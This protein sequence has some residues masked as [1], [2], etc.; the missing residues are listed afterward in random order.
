MT[1]SLLC[2]FQ[3]VHPRQAQMEYTGTR[4][5]AWVGLAPLCA[6]LFCSTL[7]H[8]EGVVASTGLAWS[9]QHCIT[10]AGGKFMKTLWD[11]GFCPHCLCILRFSLLILIFSLIPS[12]PSTICNVH[13]DSTQTHP[14][15]PYTVTVPKHPLHTH[16]FASHR[17]CS[18]V[19]TFSSTSWF[20]LLPDQTEMQAKWG[21]RAVGQACDSWFLF[22]A[23]LLALC[24]F[25]ESLS[26]VS[27]SQWWS[28]QEQ[29]YPL[30]YFWLSYV[31]IWNGTQSLPS[32]HSYRTKLL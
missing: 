26:L 5:R 4:V 23:L 29:R 25:F 19:G 16:L 7:S 22:S 2:L 13:N 11:S 32:S 9:R 10:W 18:Q 31:L 17:C 3:G 14:W 15:H 21:E 30:K 6:S 28:Q 24:L 27:A 12:F 8:E 1:D 20:L